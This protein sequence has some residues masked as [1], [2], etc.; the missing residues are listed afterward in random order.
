MEMMVRQIKMRLL[1]FEMKEVRLHLE[2]SH[3]FQ[4]L[5]QVADKQKAVAV[6]VVQ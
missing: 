1:V 2:Q 4:A 6:Q 5:R 3:Q